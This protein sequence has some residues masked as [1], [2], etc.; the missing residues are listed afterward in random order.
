MG[1]DKPDDAGR[2]ASWKLGAIKARKL[3]LEGYCQTAGCGR[4]YTFDVDDL[5]ASAGPD[6]VVPEILPGIECSACGGAL[7]FKLAMMPPN[8]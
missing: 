6:Y 8:A 4:F 2:P 3:A 7:K 1:T 5:I